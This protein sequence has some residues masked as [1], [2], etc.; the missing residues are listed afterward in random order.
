MRTTLSLVSCVTC[1]AASLSAAQPIVKSVEIVVGDYLESES[2][3]AKAENFPLKRPFG[4]DFDSLGNMYIVELEGGRVHR[5]TPGGKPEVISGDGSKSYRGDGGPIADA[6]YNGMHN[7]A[8]NQQDQAFIADSWNHC[9]RQ[10]DLKSGTIKT[11][12]GNGTAGFSGD[13]GRAHAA[14]FDFLMCVSLSPGGDELYIA[15]LK[16][17]RIRRVDLTSM[18][19]STVAGNGKKGVP[20]DGAIATESPLVDPRA[21]A[22]DSQGNVY[23]LERGGHAL[24][25]IDSEG[26][27]QTVAGTGQKGFVDGPALESQLDSPK[28]ICIDNQDRVYIADDA[29]AAVRCYDPQSQ[30][31]ST[32]LGRGFGDRRLT[33]SQPHGVTID[34][35]DLFVCDT[36]HNRIL[37]VQFESS[38][39]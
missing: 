12:I 5:I 19:V 3:P 38:G 29:N 13:G 36:S 33:L 4:I 2:G 34:K 16:N 25:R 27:I 22:V 1:F 26:T 21:V 20:A 8:I 24:R 37:R 32:I 6:T 7:I 10:I 15:D 18:L 30:T 35:G 9:V 14:Q 31:I 28:H 23:I 11:S 17:L 39:K